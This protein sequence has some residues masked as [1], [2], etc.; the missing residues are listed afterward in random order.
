MFS[1][2]A[3]GMAVL[4]SLRMGVTSTD[5]QVMGAYTYLL[6]RRKSRRDGTA[7]TNLGG[8]KDVLHGHGDL[9]ANAITLNQTDE[10]VALIEHNCQYQI[11]S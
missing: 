6:A 1:M 8:G 9:R 3:S 11:F 7:K 4:P 5:S 2:A 10:E